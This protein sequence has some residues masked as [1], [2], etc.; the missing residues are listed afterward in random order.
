VD[1]ITHLAIGA[2]LGAATAGKK[3]GKRAIVL[4]AVAQVLPDIDTISALW[5]NPA[6][7]VVSHRYLTHSISFTIVGAFVLALAAHCWMLPEVSVRTWIKFFLLQLCV[8]LLLDSFNVYG[9]AWAAPFSDQRISFNVL[10]VVD[11]FLSAP[12]VL[13]ALLT[14]VN[15]VRHQRWAW[16]GV[17][18]TSLYLSYALVNKQLVN[19]VIENTLSLQSQNEY[20]S[21]PTPFNVWLWYVVVKKDDGFLIGYR[22]VF[23][24]DDKVEFVSVPRQD[25]LLLPYQK[26]TDVQKLK[27]F[28]NGYYAVQSESDT[29]VFSDLRFGQMHGWLNPRASFVFYY[30]IKPYNSDNRTVMQRGRAEG[31]T[32]NALKKMAR[33]VRGHKESDV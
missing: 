8:H 9:V 30:F 11:P 21:T 14:G 26:R 32:W 13:A 12:L 19:R 2:C 6:S 33:R 16:M 22:S 5:L 24:E 15:W 1:T 31:W 4:G 23:D 7:S 20:L 10:F 3:L 28:S 25:S 29:L 17:L 27:R 18:T